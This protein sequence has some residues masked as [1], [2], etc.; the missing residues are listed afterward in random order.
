MTLADDYAAALLPEDKL[1]RMVELQRD[2]AV[3]AMVGDGV[4]DAPV[5][6]QAQLSIAMGSGALVSQANADIVLLSGRLTGLLDAFALAARTRR[7]VYENL[8]WA[9]GYNLAA[10]PLAAAGLVSPWIAGLGMGVSSLLVVLNFLTDLTY[11]WLDRRIQ[12]HD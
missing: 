4:N 9:A 6:A 10:L 2:G 5:L 1:A 3:V 7:V 8:T 11:T 12:L